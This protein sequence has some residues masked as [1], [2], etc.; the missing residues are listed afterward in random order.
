MKT[1]LI[2]PPVFIPTN[3][4]LSIPSLT[5]FLRTNRIQTDQ[6]DLNIEFFNYIFSKEYLSLL[7]N[8]SDFLLYSSPVSQRHRYYLAGE[9]LSFLEE[10][11]G[12]A[13][14][15]LKNKEGF[16]SIDR[17]MSARA[18]L[19]KVFLLISTLYAPANINWYTFAIK[20]IKNPAD[21][22]RL[23]S[24]SRINPFIEIY[25]R[26]FLPK[27][28]NGRYNLIGISV[29]SEDQIIP[30]FTLSRLLK[31][32]S[33]DIHIVF[34]GSLL[35]FI[36]KKLYTNIKYFSNYLDS[37]I[38]YEGEK[39]LLSLAE[40][41]CENNSFEKVPNLLYFLGNEISQNKTKMPLEINELPTPDF[42]GLDMDLY[43][44]PERVIPVITS[45]GCYWRKCA[46]CQMPLSYQ[47]YTERDPSLVFKDLEI[48]QKKYN[49]RCFIFSDEATSPKML[50]ELSTLLIKN[51]K[52]YSF[53]AFV[54]FEPQFTDKL[55]EKI[56]KAGFINLVFGLE[57]I[58]ERIRKLMNKGTERKDI[59]KTLENCSK[60]KIITHA[61]L[62]VNFP[63]ETKD[64][65]LESIDFAVNNYNI[66]HQVSINQF[67]FTMKSPV[68]TAPEKYKI[69][70]LTVTKKLF[71]DDYSGEIPQNFTEKGLS[72]YL[73]VNH[74]FNILQI[75]PIYSSHVLLYIA[76]MRFE[77]YLDFA[78]DYSESFKRVFL[79]GYSPDFRENIDFISKLI[80]KWPNIGKFNAYIAHFYFYNN[81]KSPEILINLEK[82]LSK[83]PYDEYA[84]LLKARYYLRE[85][86][87]LKAETAM[88]NHIISSGF[89]EPYL[90]YKE[91]GEIHLAKYN[92]IK[93]SQNAGQKK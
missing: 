74:P 10:N 73:M 88:K 58:N 89:E 36:D 34:G 78:K 91:Y 82:A 76:K 69:S 41:I 71:I 87:L 53:T 92:S 32:I 66:L 42:D 83:N 65:A 8:R 15:A 56:H 13:L 44:Q 47:K 80:E 50:D 26:L 24:D 4:Y 90:P 22:N 9:L 81:P 37:I 62:I 14:Q 6:M 55:C 20:P 29:T 43:I 67:G 1:L 39:P 31:R 2:M 77:R 45:R 27:I 85:K 40:A 18:I 59:E 49:S 84:S 35:S 70:G 48:L 19:Q 61:G 23:T 12:W 51:N 30:A 46:F 75:S 11:L 16:Y 68:T 21:L 60:N 63:T 3:P 72:E 7:K 28:I 57:S 93:K 79:D 64:E 17:Y 33:P 38:L 86:D 25:E 5:A 54:R 52:E